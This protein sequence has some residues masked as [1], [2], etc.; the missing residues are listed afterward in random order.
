MRKNRLPQLSVLLAVLAGALLAVSLPAGIAFSRG[1]SRPS[2]APV[3]TG[4]TYQ[5]Y[6]ESSNNPAN[7]PFDFE[8]LLFDAEAGGNQVGPT[9]TSDDLPVANGY[10]QVTL[11]FGAGR[12]A[13][14]SAGCRSTSGREPAMEPIPR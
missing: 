12:L 14:A 8:F 4:F 7:G 1:L 13:A 3:G 2:L 5:G 9:Q 10:F 6:L 11:D